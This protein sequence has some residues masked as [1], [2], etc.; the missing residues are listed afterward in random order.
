[1]KNNKMNILLV[2]DDTYIL[3]AY[4]DY[5]ENEGFRVDLTPT[6]KDAL[7]KVRK[8]PE[9][10]DFILI[11][12]PPALGLLTINALAAAN[13][14]IIPIQCEYYALEG[15][16]QLLST[17]N[18]VKK[19]LNDKLKI[20]GAIMTMYDPRTRLSEQVIEEVRNYFSEK[21]YKTIIPRNVRLSEAPSYGKPIIEYDPGCKGAKAY[22]NFTREVIKNG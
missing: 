13:E 1:M 22:S 7:Y 12:C 6:G 18:L 5:L 19:N 4:K 17:I 3:E 21:V 16:G 2:D 11:D 8:F 9:K 10:Y 20:K 14:V 15:L